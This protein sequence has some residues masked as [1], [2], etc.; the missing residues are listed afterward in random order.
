[1]SRARRQQTP[2]LSPAGTVLPP[3][4]SA[5]KTLLPLPVRADRPDALNDDAAADDK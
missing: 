5:G 4:G 3:G 1:M 2:P